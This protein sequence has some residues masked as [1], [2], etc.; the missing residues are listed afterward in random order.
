MIIKKDEKL[1]YEFNCI[2]PTEYILVF[3]LK[4]GSRMMKFIF[5]KAK[6]EIIKRKIKTPEELNLCKETEINNFEVPLRFLKLIKSSMGTSLKDVKKQVAE[7]KITICN[8]DIKK[9]IYEKIDDVW[10]VKI[11]YEGAYIDG[12]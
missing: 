7:D 8:C 2:N 10:I 6:E 9:G 4:I 1:D 3:K 11:V 12:N 5:N